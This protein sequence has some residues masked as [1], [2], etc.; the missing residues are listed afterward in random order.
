LGAQGAGVAFG[1]V[2]MAT[3][4][5]SLFLAWQVHSEETAVVLTAY[6][7]ATPSDLTHEGLALRVGLVNQSL[8]PIIVRDASLWQGEKR[9]GDAAGYL[10]DVKLLEQS[11]VNP[12]AISDARRDL[13]ITLEARE[14]RTVA[15]L[16][17]VWKPIVTAASPAAELKARRELNRFRDTIERLPN[18]GTSPVRLRIGRVPGGAQWFDV[19]SLVPPGVYPEA[20]RD[21]SAL[22]EQDR[23][24]LW[25]V[26]PVPKGTRLI[27]LR[28]R[29]TVAGAG[30]VDVVRLTVW[31]ER[32]RR[33]ESVTRPVVGEQAAL[34]PLPPLPPGA[35]TS[36]FELGDR[37]VT[38][39]AFR[40]PWRRQ[41]RCDAPS[42]EA[43]PGPSWC[44]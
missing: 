17:D 40:L 34:F 44:P 15:V 42:A 2:G 35:Y 38:H 5:T 6:P 23:V 20:I 31:K 37:V 32:S 39:F 25:S 10:E 1:L 24:S 13:P 12:A 16:I 7:A 11:T 18:T 14:G 27:G 36:A 19:R 8:R 3:G 29:R 30:Q 26:D 4:I 33:S 43:P 22:V 28:L 9:V 21:A 41:H